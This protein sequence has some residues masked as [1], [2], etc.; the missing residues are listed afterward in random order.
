MC[1]QLLL[2]A[3]YVSAESFDLAS[4]ALLVLQALL[5]RCKRGFGLAAGTRLLG[6]TLDQLDQPLQGVTAVPFL[7]AKPTGVDNKHPVG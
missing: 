4:S 6:S 1:G 2:V 3:R 7:G 5:L